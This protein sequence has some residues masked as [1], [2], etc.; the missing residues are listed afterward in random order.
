MNLRAFAVLTTLLSG[1][2]FVFGGGPPAEHQQMPYFDCPSTFGLP[3]ADGFFAASGVAAA[4]M[5]FSQ[6]EA[7]YKLKNKNGNRNAA[8]SIN[9]VMAAAFASSAIYGIVQANRCQSAKDALKERI[10]GPI[11]LPKP[12]PK[13]PPPLPPAPAPAPVPV[14]APA[15]APEIPPAPAPTAPPPPG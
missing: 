14:P 9:I 10:M 5:T 15:P 13:A 11:L 2:S 3:V 7:E 1:C 12:H 6:S 4:A 8:G